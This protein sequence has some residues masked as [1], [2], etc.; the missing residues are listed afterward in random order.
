MAVTIGVFFT[1][2]SGSSV[3]FEPVETV[4]INVGSDFI[5]L[6]GIETESAVFVFPAVQK[7]VAVGVW[8][9]HAGA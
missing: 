9:I 3:F 1:G 6:E 4:A 2:V 7:A 8:A 5:F